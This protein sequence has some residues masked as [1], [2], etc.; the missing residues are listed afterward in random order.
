MVNECHVDSPTNEA[1]AF[2]KDERGYMLETEE[3][4]KSRIV[5]KWGFDYRRV[6]PLEASMGKTF[7]VGGM[8]FEVCTK[9]CFQVAGKGWVTDFESIWAQTAYDEKKEEEE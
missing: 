4:I 1:F 2:E 3:S 5:E 6:I 9:V 7:E 8:W